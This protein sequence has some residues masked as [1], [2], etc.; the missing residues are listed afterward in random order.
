VTVRKGGV[1]KE[2]FVKREMNGVQSK[3]RGKGKKNEGLGEGSAEVGL[4]A[5]ATPGSGGR[6][7]KKVDKKKKREVYDPAG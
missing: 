1:L 4:L 2:H 6:N 5:R 3:D 7:S